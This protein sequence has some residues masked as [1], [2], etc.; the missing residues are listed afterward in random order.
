M[1]FSYALAACSQVTVW[2][3]NLPVRDYSKDVDLF[4]IAGV[5]KQ[6]G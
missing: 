3:L 4:P 5:P 6:P 2:F 1:V